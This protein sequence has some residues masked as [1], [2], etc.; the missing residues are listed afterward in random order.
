[1]DFVEYAR[2]IRRSR[3]RPVLLA[4]AVLALAAAHM[5]TDMIAG[6]LLFKKNITWKFHGIEW[7]LTPLCW[8]PESSLLS[9]LSKRNPMGIWVFLA[10]AA[11]FATSLL[12]TEYYLAALLF[13][14]SKWQLLAALA[15]MIVWLPVPRHFSFT[16]QCYAWLF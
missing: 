4:L 2:P 3:G 8:L 15:L 12:L 7:Q 14:R 6:D 13:G 1:M 16:Y 10:M 9:W 11:C 5:A